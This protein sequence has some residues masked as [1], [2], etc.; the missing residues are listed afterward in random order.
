MTGYKI[1]KYQRDVLIQQP[2]PDGSFYNP[3]K[4]V[5]GDYFIFEKEYENCGLGELTEYTPP[6]QEEI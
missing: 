1:F 3:V 4:D 6:P 2:M 5:N